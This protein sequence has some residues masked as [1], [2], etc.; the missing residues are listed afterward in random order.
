ML[1]DVI[2]EISNRMDEL[3]LS[4]YDIQDQSDGRVSANHV[5]RIIARKQSPSLEKLG[6]ILR[7]LGKTLEVVD[8]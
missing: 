1:C 8:N 6:E 5:Y 3:G 4:P 7:V 2:G